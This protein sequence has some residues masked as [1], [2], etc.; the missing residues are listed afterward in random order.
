MED[1]YFRPKAYSTPEGMS[2][3]IHPRSVSPGHPPEGVI[4][5][6]RTCEA[7]EP[8]CHF[9]VFFSLSRWISHGL[10]NS[11]STGA[12]FCCSCALDR[13]RSCQGVLPARRSEPV[14][15]ASASPW[16]SKVHGI[17]DSPDADAWI[18]NPRNIVSDTLYYC[19]CVRNRSAPASVPVST[20]PQCSTRTFGHRIRSTTQSTVGL[21]TSMA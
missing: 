12:L 3:D 19:S 21:A 5:I 11:P 6:L 17:R 16:N 14:L 2:P 18:P 9:C 20:P 4:R 10:H 1:H 7:T 15:S 8:N 13:H